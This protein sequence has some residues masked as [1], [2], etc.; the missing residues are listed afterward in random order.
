MQDGI[1][2]ILTNLAMPGLVKIGMTTRYEIH[3][4]MNE[5]NTTA[6]PVPFECVYA[7]K[8]ENIKNVENAFHQAFAPYRTNS[9]R[10]FFEIEPQ[11]AIVLLS[12]VCSEEVTPE[13]ARFINQDVDDASKEAS[14]RLNSRRP[15]FNFNEMGI[16]IGAIL[17]SNFNNDSCVVLD[18]RN[19]KYKDENTSL[20]RATRLMLE[21]SYN[22]NPCGYW[23][24]KG[25]K[26]SDIYNETYPVE[27][28]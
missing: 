24:Y 20:S 18:S 7:G 9:K 27:E 26:L 25:R 15:R 21:Y 19:V 10:K 22:V 1:I 3:Q 12:L 16:E 5:L 28:Y 6:L 14:R 23:L 17:I 11:Q 8:T 2:Y 4:R 13:V